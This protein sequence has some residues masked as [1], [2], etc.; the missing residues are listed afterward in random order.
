MQLHVSFQNARGL[1]TLTEVTVEDCERLATAVT[2]GKVIKL[3][4][5]GWAPD[6]PPESWPQVIVNGRLVTHFTVQP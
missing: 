2:D 4:N 5:R 3:P 1:L 6:S